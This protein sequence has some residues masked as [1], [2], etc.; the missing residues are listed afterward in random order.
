MLDCF[1]NEQHSND[2]TN[3]LSSDGCLA[4]GEGTSEKILECQVG[5]EPTTSVTLVTEHPT[6]A[7][8]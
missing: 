1:C 5:I 3:V 7:L 2:W 4:M 6:M 8:V